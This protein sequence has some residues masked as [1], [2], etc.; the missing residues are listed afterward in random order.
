MSNTP[1]PQKEDHHHKKA[2]AAVGAGAVVGAG[3]SAYLGGLG[4]SVGG[5]AVGI[6]I[7]TL[8]IAGS[9]VGLAGY[10]L[11]RAFR[12]QNSQTKNERNAE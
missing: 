9:V 11:Y 1:P 12:K 10:G 8:V 7:M 3:K 5:T 6:E 2:A 4:L